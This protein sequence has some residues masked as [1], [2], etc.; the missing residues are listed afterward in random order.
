MKIDTIIK[1]P[2]NID[3]Q[4]NPSSTSH[5]YKISGPLGW[6]YLN[7]SRLDKTGSSSI[8]VSLENR[9]ICMSGLDSKTNVLYKKLI[10]NKFK[11]VSRG[12]CVTL[13]IVG[14][15]YRAMII[16]D[17]YSAPKRLCLKV[18]TSHDIHYKIPNGIGIFLQSPTSVCIFGVDLN[19]VTQCAHSIRS[20]RAPSRYKS[21]G[22]RLSTE[23]IETKAGKR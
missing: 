5:S 12:F 3:I 18:G 6:S 21:K 17:G 13:D 4:R 10:E 15:G 9:S 20:T 2:D 16:G 7:L 1:I 14:V 8:R 22:I 23:K 11:G 19:Q